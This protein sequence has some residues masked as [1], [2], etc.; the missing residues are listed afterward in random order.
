MEKPV[1]VFWYCEKW[2][3]GGIQAVQANLL[4][5]MD[6]ARIHFDIV[7]SE[8]ET[9][10]FDE[11]I[12]AADA[13]RMVSLERHIDGAGRRTLLNIFA[14]RRLIWD[15]GYD[16]VHFNACHGVELVYLFWA[17]LYRVPLRIVHC[18]NND[19]GA[20]GRLRPV[21]IL[22]HRLCKHIFAGCANVHLANSDLAAQ[23]LYP[24]RLLQRGQVHI[25]KNGIDAGRYAFDAGSRKRMRDALGV[26]DA[27]VMGHVGHFS[28]QKN[29]E[30][31]LEV[32][33]RVAKQ[34]PQTVLLLVGAGEGEAD[35]R[36]QADALGVADRVVFYG[37]TD[38]VPAVMGAMD[39]FVLPSRFEGFGN[40]LIEAQANGLKC[41]AS[42]GVIPQAAKVCENLTWLA[43]EDGP[44]AW[45]EIIAQAAQP[46]ARQSRLEDVTRAGYTIEAMAARLQGLYLSGKLE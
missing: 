18:R 3:P 38:D 45:A 8:A 12:S 4:A 34:V 37:V 33:A 27:F 5:H 14:L 22:C 23:W 46:Y 35:V 2:Q 15:G 9:E 10:I 30:F 26:T 40:V 41:F 19:I 24:K 44:D 28:Y 7:T 39:A 25:M 29:H 31:L 20:G 11:K 16:A 42:D 36:A 6:T 17:W 13:R 43:L 21:K 1:R 32:F